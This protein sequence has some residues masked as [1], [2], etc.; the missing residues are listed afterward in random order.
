[1]QDYFLR[2]TL[3]TLDGTANVAKHFLSDICSCLKQSF[4]T[5]LRKIAET[6]IAKETADFNRAR[7]AK[8]IEEK[9]KLNHRDWLMR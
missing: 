7:F 1:M 8:N 9:V 6:E 4:E 2:I 5:E 3:S